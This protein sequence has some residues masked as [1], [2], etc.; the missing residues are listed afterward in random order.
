MS[1]I[2]NFKHKDIIII[3]TEYS[4]IYSFYCN[5]HNSETIGW[6]TSKNISLRESHVLL[7][8]SVE[9]KR[10][11]SRHYRILPLV[12]LREPKYQV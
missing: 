11:P 2:S 3:C 4:W 7:E 8:S 1:F 10:L 6:I 12:S 5:D 9:E